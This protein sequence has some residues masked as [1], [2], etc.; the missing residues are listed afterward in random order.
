MLVDRAREK[1][2][3]QAGWRRDDWMAADADAEFKLVR[4]KV[5]ERDE[6]T[7]RFCGFRAPKW[8]EVHHLD[9]NHHNNDPDNLVTACMFCHMVHHL[10]LAGENN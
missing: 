4:Q 8:Q 9:D 3:S 2:R 10:G 1:G 7:C 5:L 6:H